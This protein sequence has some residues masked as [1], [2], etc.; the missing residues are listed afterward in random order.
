M[1]RG[2]IQPGMRLPEARLA[3]LADGELQ[4]QTTDQIF[5]GVRAAVISVPGAFTPICTRFHIPRYVE[6][7]PQILKYSLLGL[8][9]AYRWLI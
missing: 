8:E 7:A 5:R 9:S 4:T 2:V 1:K 3:Y 6:L